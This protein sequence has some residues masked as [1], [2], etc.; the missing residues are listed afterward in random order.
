[1]KWMILKGERTEEKKAVI[2]SKSVLEDLETERVEL[3]RKAIMEV[4]ETGSG[5]DKSPGTW[6]SVGAPVLVIESHYQRTRIKG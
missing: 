2:P 3:S 1:M 5:S 4:I 6:V